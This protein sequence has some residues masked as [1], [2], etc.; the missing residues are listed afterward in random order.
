MIRVFVA[1]II[2]FVAFSARKFN[3]GAFQELTELLFYGIIISVVNAEERGYGMKTVC[4]KIGAAVRGIFVKARFLEE[5]DG[6]ASLKSKLVLQ[7]IISFAFLILSVTNIVS[8][9]YAMLIFTGTGCLLNSVAALLGWKLRNAKLCAYSAILTCASLFGFFV[10]YGGND[11]FACLWVVLLPFLA[12]V[13]MDLLAG[14][15]ASVFFQIFLI[16]VFWT[17]LR[18]Q[19]FYRYNDQFCLRFPLFFFVTF[20]LGLSLTVSLK[21]SQYNECR[22]LLELEEMT[23]AARNLARIDPLTGL[24]NRRCAYEEFKTGYTGGE[25]AH[26]LVI[27]DIDFFKRLNDTYGHEFGDEVLVTVAGYFRDCLPGDYL[28][29]RWGG[30]EFLI[31]ANEPISDV[32]ARTEELRKAIAEHKFSFNGEPVTVTITFG[33]AEYTGERDLPAAINTADNRLYQGKKA[34][35]NCTVAT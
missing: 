5:H 33:I 25:S 8:G 13:V 32:C 11:G 4:G 26:C 3:R 1:P 12:M 31:A 22:H 18:D 29:S 17:P 34:S 27:G 19:L 16:A 10:I 2:G 20:L 23:E 9:S 7:I 14:I 35:R 28:K 6:A 21:N 30:E 24:A 15:C